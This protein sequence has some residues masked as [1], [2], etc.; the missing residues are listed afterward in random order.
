M[1]DFIYYLDAAKHFGISSAEFK[2]QARRM[3]FDV[4][5]CYKMSDWATVAKK[6]G[7]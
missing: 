5:A 6:F 3:G 7:K 4:H 2:K 1:E